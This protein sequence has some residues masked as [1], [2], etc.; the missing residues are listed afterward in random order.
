MERISGS[1][2]QTYW[3]LRHHTTEVHDQFLG[4]IMPFLKNTIW[5]SL[6][7]WTYI[8]IYLVYFQCLKELQLNY[9]FAILRKIEKDFLIAMFRKNV[10]AKSTI[11]FKS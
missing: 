4:H 2:E 5:F 1:D 11:N 7:Y 3:Y 9:F 6:L 10:L 8:F